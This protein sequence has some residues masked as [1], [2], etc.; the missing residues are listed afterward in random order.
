MIA[1]HAM[2]NKMELTWHQKPEDGER[3]IKTAGK[4]VLGLVLIAAECARRTA[5]LEIDLGAST[6]RLHIYVKVSGDRCALHPETRNGF[7]Q[8]LRIDDISIRNV[9]AY[10]CLQI[11]LANQ[12]ALHFSDKSPDTLLR[13]NTSS[14]IYLT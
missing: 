14:P 6:N 11:S 2:D 7:D 4:M 9:V 3:L 5:E 1:S 12:M 10:N 13:K 8:H